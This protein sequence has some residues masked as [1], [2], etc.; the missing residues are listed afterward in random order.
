MASPEDSPCLLKRCGLWPQRGPGQA[1]LRSAGR[2]WTRGCSSSRFEQRD[3]MGLP[4]DLRQH[5][6][7]LVAGAAPRGAGHG[8]LCGIQ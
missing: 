3:Q 7:R 6:A 8:S 5:A 1:L 2:D 4:A